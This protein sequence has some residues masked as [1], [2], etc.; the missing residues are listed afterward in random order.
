MVRVITSN[1]FGE[2]S[3]IDFSRGLDTQVKVELEKRVKLEENNLL[4]WRQTFQRRDVYEFGEYM[5]IRV[6]NVNGMGVYSNILPF[7]QPISAHRVYNTTAP[8]GETKFLLNL[9]T[10]AFEVSNQLGL[11]ANQFL[12]L[13]PWLDRW[14]RELSAVPSSDNY[15]LE[16][17]TATLRF[18]RWEKECSGTGGGIFAPVL[19]D[20]EKMR[21][22][23]FAI[24]VTVNRGV[25]FSKRF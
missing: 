8:G 25:V 18:D 6:V 7:G 1:G 11:L 12:H 13:K 20:L 21:V 10:G 5:V 15:S 23:R 4:I 17:E 19:L 14:G 2:V 24:A 3:P 16:M 22:L 9:V